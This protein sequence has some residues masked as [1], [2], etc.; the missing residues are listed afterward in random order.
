MSYQQLAAGLDADAKLID[1]AWAYELA[2]QGT[3]A[4]LEE[5][6]DL[7]AVYFT[8]TDP[9]YFLA[10]DIDRRVIDVAYVRAQEVLILAAK[11]FGTSSET[12]AWQF[13]LRERVLGE[14]FPR[15]IMERLAHAGS[16]TATLA[17]YIASERTLFAHEA[18]AVIDE[19]RSQTTAR[20]RYI[21]SFA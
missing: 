3:E 8:L 18:K 11:R 15:E 6:L 17:L 9:G 13:L 21:F 1:A 12:S 2:V 19:A 14:S 5:Y 4:S 7:A 20:K 16:S 10:H